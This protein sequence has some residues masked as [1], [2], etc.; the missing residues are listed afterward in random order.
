V[1]LR[2]ERASGPG[3]FEYKYIVREDGSNQLLEWEEGANRKLPVP[4]S[5]FQSGPNHCHIIADHPHRSTRVGLRFA[6]T[7]IPVFSLRSE[8]SWGIGDF[9]D[10]KLM[11]L[12]AE[13]TEQRVLQILPV[14]DTTMHHNWID[15]YP[16]GG[17]S[18]MALHPLYACIEA[19]C[20]DDGSVDLKQ[21]QKERKRLNSLPELD[22]DGV[23]ALKWKALRYVYE[24]TA[25]TTLKSASY[26]AYVKENNHWLQPYALFCVLRDIHGTADFT[27]WGKYTNYDPAFLAEVDQKQL[28]LHIFIQYHLDKQLVEARDFLNSKG[29]VLK[30]DI[31]IGI[32]P[33]S[34]EAWAL[35]HLFHM[36]SQAG[37]PPD[38]FSAHGQNWGFPTYNWAEMEKD[39]YAW[40]KNRFS[41]MARYFQAYRIDHI[42]GFFRIWT[43]PAEHASG[44]LG[45]FDPALPFSTEE[46]HRNGVALHHDRMVRPYITDWVLDEIFGNRAAEV[47]TS[48]VT[49][50]DFSGRYDLKEPFATQ[51]K[52]QAHFQ[53]L[54]D[55]EP[56]H[57]LRDGL[58]DLCTNVLFIEQPGCPGAYHP[59]ISAQFSLSY[60]ALDDDTKFAFNKLYDHFFY[61]RHNEFW[62][63]SAMKKLPPLISA[64]RMLCCAEDLG[65]I[66][67]CV[68]PVM[69]ELSML[70]LEVQRMPKDT[71]LD[72]GNPAH[73]PY[74]CVCT[75][76]THD[77]STLRGWWEEDRAVSGRFYHHF[78]GKPG[79]APYYCEPSLCLEIIERHLQ[80]P[81]MLCI[82]PW[83]D[84]MSISG[85]L[86]REDPHRER[87]N[88]PAIVPH[89]WRYRMHIT[90]EALLKQEAF[91]ASLKDKI[92]AAGR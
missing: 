43:I 7:A 86:R 50:N 58:M 81:A 44:L 73:Y 65:M 1:G 68:H 39:G 42:L 83:Q 69:Q 17:I 78:L 5:S 74:L 30:G 18:V 26:R 20:P 92:K 88:I 61:H 59:R 13:K 79:D 51:R 48:Y 3:A 90:L 27:K 31:P 28:N 15:S 76:G 57:N 32:T 72:F 35:P 33:Q 85:K 21:F 49:Y 14:N 29:L 36:E 53:A 46:L 52:I 24:K 25:D 80:S 70:S 16:Y 19:M 47:K 34:V 77:M 63:H 37:A 12:W 54:P 23:A 91:N 64:T 62:Y 75:T 56:H 84:W 67:D 6:G 41:Y 45:Y 66:P 87:I 60:K 9:E 4:G 55:D 82:L 71:Y 40:W 89:Y 38:E 8:K 10:L 11:A 22:Y 2:N